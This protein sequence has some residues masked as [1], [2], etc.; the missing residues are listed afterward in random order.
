MELLRAK[1]TRTRLSE[2]VYIA[3]NA[4]LPIAVLFLV[5]VEPPYLAFALVIISKWRILALRP[6][7][8]WANIKSNLADL[9]VGIS[10]VGLLYLS[11]GSFGVQIILALLYGVWLLVIKPRSGVQGS[12][13]QAGIAQFVGLTTLFHYSVLLDE[14]WVLLACWLLGYVAARHVISNY[15]ETYIELLSVM[16]GLFLAELGWLLYRWTAVYNLGLPIKIPQI[17]LIM[18]VI[19]F[20]A[21]RLYGLH[22]NERL[23]AGTLRGTLIFGTALLAVIVAFTSWDGTV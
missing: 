9:V 17:A 5:R 23:T 2:M 22:K 11:T 10:T 20:C 13:L 14:P 8:W 21:V 7:F 16:W 18:V 1:V 12:I 15:E 6:R 4:L 3:L 19:G